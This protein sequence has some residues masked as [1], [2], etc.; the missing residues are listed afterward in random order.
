MLFLVKIRWNLDKARELADKMISGEIKE[1]SLWRE[2]SFCL[3]DDPSVGFDLYEAA[4]EYDLKRKWFPYEP[5][6]TI[7]EI[8]PVR[9]ISDIMEQI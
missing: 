7:L 2:D 3:V 9:R 6:G 5:Y 8:Y 1:I 4:D